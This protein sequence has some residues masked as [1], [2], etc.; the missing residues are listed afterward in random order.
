[1]SLAVLNSPL[2]SYGEVLH[3]YS[4]DFPYTGTT[5]FASNVNY[6]YKFLLFFTGGRLYE[7][8]TYFDRRAPLM[9]LRDGYALI[10]PLGLLTPM[11]DNEH[12]SNGNC[13]FA[14]CLALRKILWI[15]PQLVNRVLLY[16]HY[17]NN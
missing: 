9:C 3:L 8:P 1:M 2:V 5:H 16:V 12:I 10:A 14:L 4:M 17:G 13:L 11:A 7:Q 6:G 15:V